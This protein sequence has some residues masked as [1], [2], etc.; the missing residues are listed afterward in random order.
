MAARTVC[1][2]HPS[3]AAI[4]AIEAPSAR[5]SMP[6]SIA[7]FVL[8]GGRPA[9]DVPMAPARLALGLDCE[10]ARPVASL[11]VDMA[12]LSPTATGGVAAAVGAVC[13][14]SAAR[15][16]ADA[17]RP[18]EMR[19]RG[20]RSVL[21]A[22]L[23]VLPA[24]AACL[25]VCLLAIVFVLWIRTAPVAMLAPPQARRS[26]PGG[27]AVQEGAV[28]VFGTSVPLG[29]GILYESHCPRFLGFWSW[30]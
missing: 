1:G 13:R 4:S 5:S 18:R 29:D 10:A 3:R 19:L 9:P 6:I 8:A 25:L 20:W 23:L 28:D 11:A 14:T 24:L 27:A 15:V 7:R 12:L 2:N 17:Y 30:D 22:G 16:A 26:G 21:R